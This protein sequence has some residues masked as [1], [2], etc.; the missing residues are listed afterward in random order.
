MTLDLQIQGTQ[1]VKKGAYLIT[2]QGGYKESQTFISVEE[3]TRTYDL[4]VTLD[5]NIQAAT[6]TVTTKTET[7]ISKTQQSSSSWG[8]TESTKYS[9]KDPEK[10]KDPEEPK[11][12]EPVLPDDP[13]DDDD[14]PEDPTPPPTP[15]PRTPETPDTPTTVY[16]EI[17]D[18]LVPLAGF[19]VTQEDLIEIF[20][21]DVPLAGLPGEPGTGIV[22]H[23]ILWTMIFA[24]SLA[25]LLL[26]SHKDQEDA[27]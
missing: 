6:A 4:N 24:A 3:G 25:G 16:I 8:H 27:A 11:D 7:D 17:P 22:S 26:L 1:E 21:D 10:P 19:P 23:T 9:Y 15:V 5:L 14:G 12:P 18:G 13:E 2:A 20:D